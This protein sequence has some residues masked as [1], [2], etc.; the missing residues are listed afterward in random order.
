MF[1]LRDDNSI[2][3]KDVMN[4]FAGNL[5]ELMKDT[6][7]SITELAEESCLDKSMIVRYLRAERMPSVKS[8]INLS[9][10]LEC[11]LDDLIQV[12]AYVR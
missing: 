1:E 7:M 3:E 10:A 6:K 8:L 2:S 9:C 11:N 12:I 5:R 4:I